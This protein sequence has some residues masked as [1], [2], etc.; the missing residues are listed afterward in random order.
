[1]TE[2]HLSEDGPSATRVQGQ[3]YRQGET[4]EV[5]DE[6]ADSLVSAT[7]YF[8]EGPAPDDD[9][10]ESGAI[11]SEDVTEETEFPGEDEWLEP[12]YEERVEAVES[13]EADAYL[14]KVENVERSQQVLD[15][16]EERREG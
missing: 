14:D 2:I 11:E 7:D 5:E 3:T 6:L 16:I 13:G 8:V 1:M 9:E 10:E 15:A 12:E 4:Y